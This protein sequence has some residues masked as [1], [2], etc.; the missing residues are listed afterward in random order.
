MVDDN[1][2]LTMI[3]KFYETCCFYARKPNSSENIF[4]EQDE[5]VKLDCP[6]FLEEMRVLI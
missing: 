5:Q 2:R 4:Y 3:C 1:F 6:G